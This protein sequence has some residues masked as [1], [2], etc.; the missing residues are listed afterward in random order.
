[1]YANLAAIPT[2]AWQAG[3]WTGKL[4]GIPVYPSNADYVACYYY[5][6]D[7]LDKHGISV[8]GIKTPDDLGNL[9]KDLTNA[10]AGVWAFDDL[11]GNSFAWALQPFKIPQHW[12]PDPSGKLQYKYEVPGAVEA[13]NWMA[14]L[15]KAGYG[16]PDALN[17]NNFNGKQRFQS[18]KVA[19]VADGTGAGDGY[20]AKAGIA[21]NSTYVREAFKLF[22]ADGQPTVEL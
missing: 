15:V 2:G 12:T 9:G 14:K 5:R 13:L 3:V 20:D 1:K 21:A 4:Y 17:A 6:K 10:K 8:D 11:V 16:H 7:I 22:S 18:G 19:V